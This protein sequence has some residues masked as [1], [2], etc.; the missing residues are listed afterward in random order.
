MRRALVLVLALGSCEFAA[1][2]TAVTA[3]ITGAT[4]GFAGCAVDSVDVKTCGVISAAAAVFLG[5]IVAI[6]N[7]VANT[8]DNASPDIAPDPAELPPDI[9]RVGT[10]TEPPPVIL[11]DAGVD[12]RPIDASAVDAAPSD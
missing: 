8:S 3:A 6:V 2:H 4:V 10:H 7:L 12:A 5:G 9:V 11:V 1:K